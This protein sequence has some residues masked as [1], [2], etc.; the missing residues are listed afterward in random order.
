MSAV[1]VN[2]FVLIQA[3]ARAVVFNENRIAKLSINERIAVALVLNRP[4][5]LDGSTLLESIDLLGPEWMRAALDV[6]RAG[7][8]CEEL[9]HG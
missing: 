3:Q 1:T 4:D 6:Q 9:A 5:L 7:V 8:T 2:P